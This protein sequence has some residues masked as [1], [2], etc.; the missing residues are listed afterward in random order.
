MPTNII[1]ST[2]EA[3]G[4]KKSQNDGGDQV[5]KTTPK[6]PNPLASTGHPTPKVPNPLASTGSSYP[7][8]KSRKLP[9]HKKLPARGPKTLFKVARSTA[10]SV[11]YPGNHA[12]TKKHSSNSSMKP[13]GS[14]SNSTKKSSI[15]A[16]SGNRFPLLSLRSLESKAG[17]KKKWVELYCKGLKEVI[18]CFRGHQDAATAL[19]MDRKVIRR[20]CEKQGDDVPIFPTFSLLHAS[21]RMHLP[22]YHYGM[23][24]EDY[25]PQNETYEERVKRFRRVYKE[26][27][28]RED[29]LQSFQS[30]NAGGTNEV[31]LSFLQ[32]N[33][34][35]KNKDYDKIMVS[36]VRDQED[37]LERDYQNI[38]IFCQDKKPNIVFQPCQHSVLCE[39]CYMSGICRKFCPICRTTILSTTKPNKIKL[40][41]PR[42]F[43]A[44]AVIGDL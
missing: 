7:T 28:K 21:T 24:K 15:A 20:M 13:T 2:T 18:C 42:V 26:D 38:C 10:A 9:M 43:S 11:P 25:T 31:P 22:A 41:R 32:S 34:G 19:S 23:H 27:R 40:V 17:S 5:V 6:I 44:Y 37:L 36:A 33:K 12:L 29:E 35:T 4:A 8:L 30:P 16:S 1:T 14:P 3:G 39:E